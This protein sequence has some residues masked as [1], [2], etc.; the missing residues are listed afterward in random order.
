MKRNDLI[1]LLS[2]VTVGR[3]KT[4]RLSALP[5]RIEKSL[6]DR[7]YPYVLTLISVV[8]LALN[9]Y[10]LWPKYSLAASNLTLGFDGASALTNKSYLDSNYVVFSIY[11][12]GN[13][14]ISISDIVIDLADPKDSTLAVLSK[15][16]HVP[17][18][19][20]PG[21][22]EKCILRIRMIRLFNKRLEPENIV[23]SL[24]FA[25]AYSDWLKIARVIKWEPTSYPFTRTIDLKVRLTY[26]GNNVITIEKGFSDCYPIVLTSK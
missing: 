8:S 18:T 3:S 19:L 10:V 15:R 1:A 24:P 4:K 23:Y 9:F 11:N 12:S 13:R 26:S 17:N 25:D 6:Y 21:E 20:Q 7:I 2:R 14:A 22:Q 16:I 5:I